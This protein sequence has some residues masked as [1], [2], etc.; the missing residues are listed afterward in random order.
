MVITPFRAR[1]SNASWL[2]ASIT[3]TRM[4]AVSAK[5][6]SSSAARARRNVQHHQHRRLLLGLICI[7]THQHALQRRAVPGYQIVA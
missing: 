3:F 5:R 6:L 7:A 4:P 2:A 1:R